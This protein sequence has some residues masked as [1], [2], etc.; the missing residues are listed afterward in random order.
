[1][2]LNIPAWV[3]GL[4][5]LTTGFLGLALHWLANC[6]RFVKEQTVKPDQTDG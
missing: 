1:L 6:S 4:A 5:A 3:W 2:L